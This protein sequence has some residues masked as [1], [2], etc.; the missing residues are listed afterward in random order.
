MLRALRPVKGLFAEVPG[1]SRVKLPPTEIKL[2]Q[3]MIE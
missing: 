1:L 3:L 2:V